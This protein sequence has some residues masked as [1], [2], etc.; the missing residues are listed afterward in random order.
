MNNE[1]RKRQNEEN[2]IAYL[3]AQKQLYSDAKKWNRAVCVCSVI[4]PFALSVLQIFNTHVHMYFYI[5]SIVS[6]AVSGLIKRNVEE[7]KGK[8]AYIQQKFDTNVYQMPWNKY[9]FDKDRNVSGIVAEKSEKILKDELK[10][11]ELVNW[12]TVADNIGVN[13]SILVCQRQNITWDIGL[14]KRYKTASIGIISVM[15]VIIFVISFICQENVFWGMF[16]VLPLF[17]RERD[18]VEMLEKD[19]ERLNKLDDMV[20]SL[21]EKK[22][23]DLQMIQREIYLHRKSCYAIPDFFYKWFKKKDNERAQRQA[24]L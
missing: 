14:R 15:I 4:L 22:M 19:I 3:A 20:N 17:Q 9:L 24:Q 1:I 13:E 18:I 16:F 21:E 10:K 5:L 7:E 8:A 6:W 12:Y 2:N 11:N 23:I